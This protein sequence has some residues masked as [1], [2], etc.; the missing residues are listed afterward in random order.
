VT[1][2]CEVH[3]VPAHQRR[4]LLVVLSINAIMFSV[5][6]VAGIVAH[7]TALLADSVDMLGDAI[8][9]GFSLYVVGRGAVWQARGALLKGSVMA[10]FG[11]GILIEAARKVVRGVTPSASMMSGIGVLAL[12]A[13]L[14]VLVFLWRHRADDINM[15]SAWL[16][17]RNDVVANAA[18]IAAAGGVALTASAWPDIAVGLLIAAMFGTSAVRVIRDGRRVLRSAAHSP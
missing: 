9:Y 16:C 1:D 4:I 2:C 14:S 6:L 3:A 13:N 15:R 5:E 7:S 8:V 10:V 18:V 12:A 11:T 17:S